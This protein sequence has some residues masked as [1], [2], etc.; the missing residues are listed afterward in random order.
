[1]SKTVLYNLDRVDRD[2]VK[3]KIKYVDH[4]INEPT[5]ED[6]IKIQ[7]LDFEGNTDK[8]LEELAGILAPTVKLKELTGQ[9]RGLFFNLCFKVLSGEC[10]ITKKWKL[11]E[12]RQE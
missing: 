9:M 2:K 1:M 4:E 10:G 8:A 6:F 11:E 3:V 12:I 5:V 7:K